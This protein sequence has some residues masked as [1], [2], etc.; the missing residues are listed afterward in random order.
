MHLKT[1]IIFSHCVDSHTYLMAKTWSKFHNF[2]KCML[3]PQQETGNSR[4]I[5][6]YI[7]GQK[8]IG[9]KIYEK[10]SLIY[11][12]NGHLK[13]FFMQYVQKV[14]FMMQNALLLQAQLVSSHR[15]F[16]VRCDV[17]ELSDGLSGRGD[18]LV[19]FLFSDM[20]EVHF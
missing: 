2:F 20:M 3:C 8:F 10:Q 1:C 14:E 4:Y 16:I 11:V 17:I 12:Q 18:S 6:I 9:R 13:F 15:S 7:G 5:F 19:F